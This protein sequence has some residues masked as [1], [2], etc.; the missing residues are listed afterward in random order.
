MPACPSP[1]E[2]HRAVELL[3][4]G[5][6]R[7]KTTEPRVTRNGPETTRAKAAPDDGDD[8]GGGDGSDGAG[9]KGG[10][11]GDEAVVVVATVV[12]G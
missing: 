2:F 5:H 7:H 6:G 3:L 12:M 1:D 9:A 11:G 8:G 10:N 4:R